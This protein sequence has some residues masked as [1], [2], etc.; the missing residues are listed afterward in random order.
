MERERFQGVKELIKQ[1]LELHPSERAAFVEEGC[2]D[3]LELALDILDLL[4]HSRSAA[5]TMQEPA[6][7]AA[8]SLRI[9]GYQILEQL[10]AGATGSVWRARQVRPR[11]DVAIKVL[12]LDSVAPGQIARFR[13]EA[14]FLAQLDHPGIAR[15][16]ESGVIDD[17]PVALPW[18]ALEFVHGVTLDKHARS[19]RP[20]LAEL[21]ELFAQVCEA[22]EHAHRRGIVHRDLKP[23]NV[24]VDRE[25]RPRVID[26]GIA[27]ASAELEGETAH[28]TRTGMLIG[29]LPFMAPEQARGER[30]LT[31]AADVYSLGAILYLVVTGRLPVDTEDRD[32][33]EAVHAVCNEDPLPARRLRPELPRDLETILDK[34]LA[35]DPRRR[36]ATAGALAADLERHLARQPVLARRSTVAYRLHRLVRRNPALTT[37]VAA[38]VLALAAGLGV[39]LVGMRR[40]QIE[41]ARST[42]LLDTVVPIVTSFATRLGFGEEDRGDLQALLTLVEDYLERNPD[43][44]QL[45]LAH[46]DLLSQLAV[47]DQARGDP[48]AMQ[49][50]IDESRGILQRVERLAP[51]DLDVQTALSAAYARSGEA[52]HALERDE[53]RDFWNAR[54]LDNDVRLVSEHPG[55]RELEEDLGWSLERVARAKIEAGEED[56]GLCYSRWRLASA[57]LL[58]RA[59]PRNWKFVY[60]LSSALYFVSAFHLERGDLATAN[61]LGLESVRQAQLLLELQPKRRNAIEFLV[62]AERNARSLCKQLGKLAEARWFCD[63]ALDH[64]LELVE[65]DP[66]RSAHLDL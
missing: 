6:D 24:M 45:L 44:V 20:S 41:N 66:S 23:S 40:E 65:Q 56:E 46:A 7:G 48:A 53:E 39:A 15:V 55:D 14:Q 29:T 63:D 5:G 22:V 36:Y 61:E 3:D 21:L 30:D 64:A 50:R 32:F 59:E 8:A 9:P 10:A 57:E 25:G 11:R 16:I 42:H 62:F 34:A 1:A 58:V 51:E 4:D 49:A 18:I 26:F 38:L 35:K 31:P 28:L 60:N 2:P 47:L 17:G 19:A 33:L 13:R 37:S 54:A 43:N 27:R 12:R 52:A